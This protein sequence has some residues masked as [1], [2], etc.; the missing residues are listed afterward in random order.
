MTNIMLYFNFIEMKKFLS[1]VF[2]VF[3]SAFVAN[4]DVR[5]QGVPVS[6]AVAQSVVRQMEYVSVMPIGEASFSFD[7]IQ[8]WTGEGENQAA[9]ILQWN[10][11]RETHAMV[12]GY[13][14]DGEATGVDM[15][16]A[17]AKN[18]PRLYILAMD[19]SSFG[20]TIGG[21]GYDVDGDGDYQ[22]TDGSETYSFVDGVVSISGY[23][24][25]KFS[26]TDSDDYWKSGWMTNGY[27]SYY[28]SDQSQFPPTE[29]AS[30][31]ASSRKLQNGSVDGWM[32][33]PFSGGP[34]SWK[35]LTPAAAEEKTVAYENGFFILNE[36]WFGHE[37]G[38]L[39]FLDGED[40]FSYR[41]FQ[42]AN[43]GTELGATSEYGQIYGENIYIMSKQGT[44]L[45]VADAKTLKV[46]K[47]FAELA[48]DGRAVL[49]VDEN[50]V[51]VGT[52]AGI[53]ILDVASLE[54]GGV[55][56]GTGDD[57][58]D[59]GMMTRVGKY[60]F[61]A[62]QS[63]GI[64]VIDAETNTLLNTIEN[65]N[66]CG[67]T[68]SKDGY[69]WV[70][71]KSEILRIHPVTLETKTFDLPN[72]MASP[73][74]SWC[75]DKLV[76][77]QKE[78]ALF[79]GYGS[80]W[81]NAETNIGKLLI[82]GNGDLSEDTSFAVTLP[83]G[84]DSSKS[85]MLYGAFAYDADTD[86]LVVPTVQSGYGA[87]YQEN[88]IHF[89]DCQSGEIVKT[90]R[91]MD[92]NGESHYWFPALV[93]PTDD[94]APELALKDIDGEEGSS[95]AYAVADFV[96]DADNLAVLSTISVEVENPVVAEADCDGL[97][98]N[99]SL[100]AEGNTMLTVTVNSNGKVA[101]KQIAVN[102]EASSVDRIDS[103]AVKI[104]PTLVKDRLTVSGVEN[105]TLRIFNMQGALVLQQ[106]LK[107]ANT[108]NVG[109][110]PQGTYIVNIISSKGQKIEKVVKM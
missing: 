61:A 64:F 94:A 58:G 39:T 25:D 56:A 17:I 82:D 11:D 59:I 43:Q 12:W 103:D 91:P 89:V 93:I 29:Y 74:G 21:F 10:D 79:Y 31:G 70:P 102:A 107:V 51:Y 35:S 80:S 49:G 36:G 46:K 96:H 66:A 54:L 106:D 110:L 40:N 84:V 92:E 15:V 78:N 52:S 3:A 13:R 22:L 1:F 57:R 2:I 53:Q 38:S 4:A 55:I 24:F 9:L 27:W 76:A 60:V 98:L 73:W 97:N 6:G 83:E 108:V 28:V 62:K 81:P 18:D 45:V 104:S 109:N 85:Q 101:Q 33:S 86:M 32:F 48:G 77:S 44:R 47:T 72:T 8:N 30:T 90:L 7:Q 37:N 34:Y 5:I 99:V 20:T 75:A 26:S 50:T 19:G 63:K 71:A 41:A 42:A 88:W 67:L 65:S 68:V 23:E 105:G 87:N 14:W 100:K 69:V 95:Y 16:K